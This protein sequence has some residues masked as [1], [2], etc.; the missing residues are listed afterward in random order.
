MARVLALLFLLK[1][2]VLKE[3]SSFSSVRFNNFLF[4][5][6]FR[7]PGTESSILEY[8][9]LSNCPPCASACYFFRRYTA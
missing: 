7:K 3:L 6:L 1:K 2:L 8:V 9:L 4:C 5:I